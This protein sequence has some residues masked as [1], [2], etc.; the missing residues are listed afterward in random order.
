[1]ERPVRRI[2]G[3]SGKKRETELLKSKEKRV[4]DRESYKSEK[5]D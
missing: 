1:M 3:Y 5:R 4:K 2:K